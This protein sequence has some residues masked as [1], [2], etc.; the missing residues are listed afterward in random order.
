MEFTVFGF[1]SGTLDTVN[2]SISAMKRKASVFPRGRK[3]IIEGYCLE[4]SGHFLLEDRFGENFQNFALLNDVAV[5]ACYGL[6]IR[7][8]ERL[9]P[10][11]I[12][13]LDGHLVKFGPW[14]YWEK[15]VLL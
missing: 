12:Q 7:L 4:L 14:E 15:E 2:L 13:S 10:I 1:S 3:R 8:G 9:G 6:G 11:E 5:D